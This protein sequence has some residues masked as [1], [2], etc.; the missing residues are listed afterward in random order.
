MGIRPDFTSRDR[1]R[2]IHRRAQGTEIYFVAN[3]APHEVTAAATFRASGKTPEFWWPDTGRIEP[4][5]MF[6]PQGDST[7]VLLTLGPSGSVFVVFHEA[8]QGGDS[9]VALARDDVPLYSIDQ[10]AP[11]IL[12][13]KA[14]YGVPNDPTRTRDV[15]G[16][17]QAKVD[18]GDASFPVAD[19]AVGDDPAFHTVKTLAVEYTIGKKR[20]AVKAQDGEPIHLSDEAVKIHVQKAVYGVL[21]DPKRTRDVRAKV[22]RIADAGE[23]SFQVARMAA[24]D[25]PAYG[26]VKT[27]VLEYLIGGKRVTATGTDPETILLVSSE[28]SQR[29]AEIRRGPDGQL[30]VETWQP[31]QY[32]VRL[33]SGQNRRVTV[34]GLPAPLEIAGPWEVSFPAPNSAPQKVTFPQLISWSG[35]ADN[36]VKY[37]SGTATYRKTFA[38]PSDA[39]S[40]QRR[41]DLDLG[42]VQAIAHV[43]LNGKD[44]GV[45]WKPPFRADVTDAFKPGEN[46]LEVRVTNLWPNRLIGDEQLPEDSQRN[47]DG[48]LKAWPQWLQEGIPSPTGRQTFTSWRLWKK[49]DALLDSGLLGPVR[50]VPVQQITLPQ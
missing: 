1:L 43:K 13:E 8:A 42:D 31:G 49:T 40:K 33:S 20:F 16:K 23:S 32:E 6:H 25:D 21:D 5:A 47:P 22:Q 27:L 36:G 46:Q 50:L 29:V 11:K 35:V 7:R 48:T 38:V 45:F 30:C 44:L 39:L 15:R 19:M 2:F 17:V 18:A 12:V 28:P 3:P 37:F 9:A 41:L 34:G 24:G 4:A 14:V 10:P 26:I